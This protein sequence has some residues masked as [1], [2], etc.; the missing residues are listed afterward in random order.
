MFNLGIQWKWATENPAR[1]VPRFQESKRERFLTTEEIQRFRE[2]LDSYEDQN[3]ANAL[4]LLMLTG[5]REGE[6]LKAEW[7]QFDFLRRVW[8]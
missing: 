2:A 1:G 6:V 4:R 8:I 7:E 5:S 3:A